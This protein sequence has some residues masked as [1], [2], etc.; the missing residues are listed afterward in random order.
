MLRHN[1]MAILKNLRINKKHL[2][3]FILLSLIIT[4][5]FLLQNQVPSTLRLKNS[6]KK[7]R[8]NSFLIENSENPCRFDQILVVYVFMSV[9]SFERRNLI[10]STWSDS[11]LFPQMKTLFVLEKAPIEAINEQVKQENSIYGD[12]IQGR[13]LDSNI[14]KNSLKTFLTWKWIDSYC[15]N[16]KYVI[17]MS[18]EILLNTFNLYDYLNV[19]DIK[20]NTFYC[21]TFRKTFSVFKRALK[22]RNASIFIF[23]LDFSIKAELI[24]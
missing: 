10:R 20:P 17:K 12:I 4:S 21:Q 1:R 24:L 2:A 6:I 11:S 23:K 18:D 14:K 16:S 7:S 15:A 9:L 19:I 5:Y 13:F 3:A 22:Q 8:S